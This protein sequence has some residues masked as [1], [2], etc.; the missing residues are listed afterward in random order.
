ML[1]ANLK[2]MFEARSI[3]IIGASGDATRIGGRPVAMLKSQGY[4]GEIYPINP[5]RDEIQGLK[6]YP[7]VLD[8]PGQVDLA[9]CAVPGNLVEGVIRQCAEKDV[10]GTV[11]FAGGF[12]E[13]S[14]AGAADQKRL[15]AIAHETGMRLNGPNC[16]G[17]ANFANNMPASFHPAFAR[18]MPTGR[19][20]LVSQ[21]GAF[22]GLSAMMACDRGVG[23]RHVLTTGNE[24]DI[25][26]ADCLDYL[27]SD[28]GTEVILLYI[29]GVRDGPALLDALA[30]AREAGKPVVAVKLG[31]TEAGARAAASH[32]SAL[33]GADQIYDAVFS[34]FGVHRVNAIEEFFDL[35]AALAVGGRPEGDEVALVTVSGGVGVLMADDAATRG[36]EVTPL[37]DATQAKFKELVPYAGV[38]NPLDVTGQIINQ[39]DLFEKAMRLVL[40]EGSYD[41][42]IGFQGALLNQPDL[43]QPNLDMWKTLRDAYPSKRFAVASLMGD[44]AQ[45]RFEAE[46]I[47]AFREPTH[48]T[49]AMAAGAHFTRAFNRSFTWAPEVAPAADPGTGPFTEAAALDLLGAAGVPTMP[50]RTAA[51]PEEAARVATELG[52]PVVMKILSPDI[53]HKTDVGGVRLNLASAE[54]VQA[55]AEDMLASVAAR[56]PEA[57]IDGV[58][59]APMISGGVETILGVHVD[60]IF[61]PAVMFGLG[62]IFVEVL[63]DV[64]FRIAPFDTDE[65]LRMIDEI[66][67]RPMLDGV[68]GAPAADIPAL[69]EALSALSRFAAA[70][71]ERLVS[72]DLNPFVVLPAGQGAMALDAVVEMKGSNGND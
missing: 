8:V 42:V 25:G 49:R 19:I 31:R 3:A 35:G 65:A 67:G 64:T 2:R 24:S 54:A 66:R 17:F 60:P 43:V 71:R 13:V 14:E 53:I 47:P 10:A 5:K 6:A 27:V 46:G 16:M 26:V 28:P 61:G 32:T 44:D 38:N 37:P 33:A 18:N 48:A 45:H 29:E 56:V 52:F 34:Q 57:R 39:P 7:S 63:K 21:S 11:I 62:G 40:E 15:T 12:A 23:F 68:R 36:L 55:A 59:L 72:V 30:R 22:G 41:T 69:A 1:D 4:A 20:G 51:T 58:L 9:I 50:T 70:H